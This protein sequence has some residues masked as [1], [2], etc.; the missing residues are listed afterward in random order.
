MGLISPGGENLLD[1]LELQQVLLTYHGDIRDPLRWPQ[2]RTVPLRVTWRLLGGLSGFLS[3]RFWGLKSCL[4]SVSEPEDSS[5]VL[6]LILVNVWSLPSGVTPRLEW[7][8][9]VCFPSEL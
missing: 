4:E 7:G 6:T 1:F 3:R 9:H 5:P 8:L 2:E